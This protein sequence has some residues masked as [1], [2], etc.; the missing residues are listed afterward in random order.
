MFREQNYLGTLFSPLTLML[1]EGQRKGRGFQH[2]TCVGAAAHP[3]AMRNA[4]FDPTAAYRVLWTRTVSRGME[5]A[6]GLPPAVFHAGPDLAA[7]RNRPLTRAV[8]GE[9]QTK[10]P[11]AP[12]AVFNARLDIATILHQLLTKP[13]GRGTQTPLSSAVCNARS[14]LSAALRLLVT[15]AVGRGMET[16]SVRIAAVL[17]TLTNLIDLLGVNLHFTFFNFLHPLGCKFLS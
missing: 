11:L 9:M 4:L 15:R 1:S 17:V 5:T 7:A 2:C 14:N 12:S 6:P 3:A 16:P 8:G 13:A 10:Q